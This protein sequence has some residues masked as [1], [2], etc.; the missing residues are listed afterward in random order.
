MGDK[1][2]EARILIVDDR[3]DK[4]ES[5]ASLVSDLG[6][7]VIVH[8]GK[9]ALRALLNEEFA[10]I[11]LDVNM[12]GMDGFE[13]AAMIRQR[14]S[15]ERTPIIFI[16]A[17]N[18]TDTHVTRGY[19][20]GAVDYIFAPPVPEI[21]RAKVA[22]FVD[23]HKKTLEVRRRATERV[24]LVREQTARVVAEENEHRASLLAEAS[25][26]LASTFEPEKVLN[27]IADLLVPRHG[28]VCCIDLFSDDGEAKRIVQHPYDGIPFP[29]MGSDEIKLP[30][31]SLIIPELSVAM[32]A[33]PPHIAEKL[34]QRGIRSMII[35]PITCAGR[36]NAGFI[37][38]AR[39][40]DQPQYA[41]AERILVED[42]SQRIG[43]GIENA[44]LY[45]EAQEINRLKDEFLAI[46][47][48]ELRTP[49]TP[50]LGWIRILNNP[51][52]NP[53]M[54]SRGL[55]V[56]E[57]NVK[58]QVKLIDDLLDVSRIVT[59]KLQ[60]NMRDVDI[61]QLVNNTM[62]SIAV[63]ANA[64]NISLQSNVAEDIRSIHVDP[65][66]IEQILW[67]LLSNSIKFTPSGGKV[68]LIVSREDKNILFSVIDNGKG[69]NSQFLPYVFDRF[70]QADGTSTRNSGGLGLGL[71]IV[72]HLVELHGGTVRATSTGEGSG[73][74]FTVSIPEAGCR[75]LMDVENALI[76]TDGI[77][78][79]GDYDL[80]TN[81]VLIV[82]DEHDAREMISQILNFTGAIIQT[83]SSA[84]E[85][86]KLL[87]NQPFDL[88]ISDLSMPGADGFELLHRMRNQLNLTTPAIAFS[89]LCR[90]EDINRALDA[91]FIQH[92]S[93]PVDP[94]ALVKLVS[95]SLM[96]GEKIRA[97]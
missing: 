8:S 17:Y 94:C 20:L 62:E 42:L 77:E 80:T 45:R 67:N 69:I 81:R 52:A 87:A 61:R 89:A 53:E 9:D 1:Q 21:L 64:K 25:R 13:T 41:S 51:N 48:H 60:L 82:D 3:P 75:D 26:L 34:V 46:V 68:K 22:V 47:S 10:V 85:A 28:S 16:T 27:K 12:P 35:S 90:P 36:S 95:S 15:F 93:K 37:M 97:S 30:L 57:R 18:N 50:I 79:L 83:A 19:S 44:R 24:Q 86:L 38:L 63:T 66:R 70:R 91:G 31:S 55:E 78:S 40:T 59:G 49:L 58:A 29:L 92:I 11:M 39:N 65:E 54:V 7:L 2:M 23:L 88:V 32:Q 5:L 33:L 74:T 56:I 4:A 73:A 71:S 84:E 43:I 14:P 6:Q 76:N 96:H 72:R